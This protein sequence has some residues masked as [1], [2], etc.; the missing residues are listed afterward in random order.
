MENVY[1]IKSLAEEYA[2]I[3]LSDDLT[4]EQR[5]EYKMLKTGWKM[6]NS[7]VSNENETKHTSSI[8]TEE[9]MSRND[10]MSDCNV[11]LGM[12]NIRSINSNSDKVYKMIQ[13][14]LDILVLVETWHGSTEN[15]SVKSSMPP[16]FR[17]VDFLRLNDPHHGGIIV[18]FKSNFKYKKIDLPPFDT[19]EVVALKFVI[20]SKD[21]VLL[22]LY[23]PGSVQVNALFLEELSKVLDNITLLS[24]S[25]LLVGD[26]NVHIERCNDRHANRLLDLFETFNLTNLISEPTHERGGT[27][28]LVVCSENF[29]VLI[30]NIF[31]S[32][33]YSDHSLIHVSIP[34]KRIC[35]KKSSQ[36][37]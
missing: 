27:L 6:E 9:V 26:F 24:S 20:N 3:G 25:I 18:F 14:G 2:G 37:S 19:F 30:S 32:G 29:H 5:Q 11:L 36:I 23:R 15:V 4:K 33:V 31:P 12:L 17:Y 16:G 13:D 8:S 22:S 34:I 7:V 10:V 1:K 35:L 21:F 28:D